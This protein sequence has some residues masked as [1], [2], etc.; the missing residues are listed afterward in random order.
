[1]GRWGENPHF[2]TSFMDDAPLQIAVKMKFQFGKAF[3]ELSKFKSRFIYMV[4]SRVKG[5]IF[6]L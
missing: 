5:K 4:K 2:T 3:Q 1:M 6:E